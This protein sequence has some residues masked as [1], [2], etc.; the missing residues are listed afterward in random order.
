[1]PRIQSRL[2]LGSDKNR[3]FFKLAAKFSIDDGPRRYVLLRGK[4]RRN[5]GSLPSDKA[6][7]YQ[8]ECINGVGRANHT[9]CAKD[10]FASDRNKLLVRNRKSRMD[11]IN[12]KP[13][14]GIFRRIVRPANLRS[15]RNILAL[16]Y[17]RGARP[18]L[19]TCVGDVHLFPSRGILHFLDMLKPVFAM[20]NFRRGKI[21]H[22]QSVA[23]WPK[24]PRPG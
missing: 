20:G 10:I 18:D 17:P 13:A 16:K 1:M 19:R 12:A 5:T 11:A 7:A 24:S 8:A 22:R 21:A 2:P 4:R 6:G 14:D 3:L 15:I 23:L 9:P